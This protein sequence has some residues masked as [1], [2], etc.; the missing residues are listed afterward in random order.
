MI[1]EPEAAAVHCLTDLAE[2]KGNLQVCSTTEAS[3]MQ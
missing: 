1:S 2:V 3:V